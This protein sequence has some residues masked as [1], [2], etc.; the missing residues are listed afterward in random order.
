M[1]STRW[2]QDES[3]IAHL[4]APGLRRA[5]DLRS[6]ALLCRGLLRLHNAGESETSAEVL[7]T[8][9]ELEADTLIRKSRMMAAEIA[10]ELARPREK[11]F[12]GPWESTPSDRAGGQLR[13]S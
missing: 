1:N 10:R 11:A 9:S 12:S 3:F 2:E 4:Y 6:A 8:R 13:G 7:K 5:G